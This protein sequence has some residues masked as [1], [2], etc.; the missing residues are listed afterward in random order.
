MALIETNHTL[1]VIDRLKKDLARFTACMSVISMIIFSAYYARLIYLN[2]NS[3]IY[4][5]IY[6]TLFICV[7]SSFIVEMS[8]KQKKYQSRKSNRTKL[9]NKRKINFCLKLLKYLAKAATIVIATYEFIK[10]PEINLS[11][12][13]NLI[14]GIL[15]LVQLLCEILTHF[16]N[17]YIDYFMVGLKLDKDDSTGIKI[18]FKLFNHKQAKVDELEKELYALQE[19]NVFTK[20]EQ[21]IVNDLKND[22]ENRKERIKKSKLEY[23]KYLNEKIKDTKAKIKEL[24]KQHKLK[25][26]LEEIKKK[27]VG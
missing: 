18:L 9:E 1:A 4:C 16:V 22:A 17:K 21:K 19:E 25:E 6:A 11:S 8:I 23:D 2:I 27:M 24:K 14:L 3:A 10:H 15:L 7:I 12:I 20:Q 13:L 5:A 26:K